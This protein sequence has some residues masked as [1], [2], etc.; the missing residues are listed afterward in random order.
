MSTVQNVDIKALMAKAKAHN[1]EQLNAAKAQL[2][3]EQSK[4]LIAELARNLDSVSKYVANEVNQL[5]NLRKRAKIQEECLQSVANAA[6][7]FEQDGDFNA[8]IKARNK[9]CDIYITKNNKLL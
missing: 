3:E 6:A 5:R 8:F 1:Q 2:A 4:R 7:Q 9:A